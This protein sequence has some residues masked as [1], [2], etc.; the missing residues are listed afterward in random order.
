MESKLVRDCLQGLGRGEYVDLV[1][2]VDDTL[3]ASVTPRGRQTLAMFGLK[4]VPTD[5]GHGM[6]EV[7]NGRIGDPDL[8]LG[9]INTTSVQGQEAGDAP[10]AGDRAEWPGNG[11][12]PEE[13][14]AH[15]TSESAREAYL[16][17]TDATPL[18]GL[19][20]AKWT[21]YDGSRNPVP[22]RTGDS[23][24]DSGV[25]DYPPENVNVWTRGCSIL[26]QSHDSL[27]KDSHYW[28]GGRRTSA[29]DVT[30][31]Y[32]SSEEYMCGAVYMEVKSQYKKGIG[33]RGWW[34][35]RTR[36]HS[37]KCGEVEWEKNGGQ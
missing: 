35:G 15:H 2:L 16:I 30:L 9:L 1:R 22:Y 26:C 4:S 12:R 8:V 27:N 32:W 33:M 17:G 25:V 14:R 34:N 24:D 19:W 20:L 13:G 28:L 18:R 7:A 11:R 6:G 36:D 37:L 10:E 29:G 5:T 23:G 21:I 3:M 31:L